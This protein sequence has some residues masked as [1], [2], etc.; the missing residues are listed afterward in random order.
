M[1]PE[2]WAQV[3]SL[4]ESAL[5]VPPQ[6]RELWLQ[7][8]SHLE[9]DVVHQLRRLLENIGND[10]STLDVPA[11]ASTGGAP[12]ASTPPRVF[13]IGEE[14]ENRF[15]VEAFLGAGGMGEVYGCSDSLSRQRVA[16]KTLRAGEGGPGL[17]RRL[18]DELVARRIAHPNVCRL[19]EVFRYTGR[20]GRELL[21]VTMQWVQGHTLSEEIRNGP[22]PLDRALAF[23]VQLGAGLQAAH[24]ADVI[25]RDLK[26]SNI[27]ISTGK[28]DSVVI[29]DFGLARDMS[30]DAARSVFETGIIAGTPAYMAP[31]Q[32]SGAPVG[33]AADI[34]AFGAVLYEMVTGKVPHEGNTAIAVGLRKLK[35]NAPSARKLRHDL[36]THWDHV[37][38]ACLERDPQHR[39]KSAADVVAQ[40][41]QKMRP[42]APRWHRRAWLAAAGTTLVSGAAGYVVTQNRSK[43]EPLS[44]EAQ[45]ALRKGQEFAKGRTEDSVRNAI[46]ELTNATRLAPH[47]KEAWNTL[48]EVYV[49]AAS[50]LFVMPPPQALANAQAAVEKSL[51]LD[52]RQSRAFGILGHITSNQIP[53]WR[54]AEQYFRRSLEL[55]DSDPLVY[56]WYATYLGRIGRQD[57]ALQMIRKGLTI[58]AASQALNHNLAVQYLRMRRYIDYL[59]QAREM[60]RL[61][62]QEPSS[63]LALSRAYERLGR[64]EDAARSC[65]DAEKYTYSVLSRCMRA[66]I[67]AGRGNVVKAR[68]IAKEIE[69]HWRNEPMETLQL[70]YVYAQ[71]KDIPKVVDLAEEG[72]R[73]GDP[74][75]IA[76]GTSPYFDGFENDEAYRR[77]LKRLGF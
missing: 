51:A 33:K 58:D 13:E 16:I 27:L 38:T 47:S 77:L 21:C 23:A 37:I 17:E 68:E 45:A 15:R 20:N 40:L 9:E 31:E 29:T 19:F 28:T 5:S 65:D 61:K 1:T 74:T 12:A 54:D 18:R 57:E 67:E 70:L 75:V 60:V 56:G 41:E 14:I 66:S 22:L 62:P 24:D 3:R 44:E 48:A 26:S 42:P 30:G 72:I 4:M 39:P 25:H 10:A 49:T 7:A 2:R 64:Y 73:R 71:L 76:I 32:F 6:E 11:W 46:L 63:H 50:F 8:H 34:Y 52:D 43:T 69:A 35:E 59:A 36:P 55:N 53:K